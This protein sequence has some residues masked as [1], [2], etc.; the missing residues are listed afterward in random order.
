MVSKKWPMSSSLWNSEIQET[1]D[2]DGQHRSSILM[3]CGSR[4]RSQ[5][6]MWSATTHC[7]PMPMVQSQLGVKSVIKYR[8]L[9]LPQNV[10]WPSTYLLGSPTRVEPPQGPKVWFEMSRS[11]QGHL[12]LLVCGIPGMSISRTNQ[13]SSLPTKLLE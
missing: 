7:W 11:I 2:L 13:G 3:E 12:T 1:S 8:L 4:Y 6:I 5:V 10:L 9:L